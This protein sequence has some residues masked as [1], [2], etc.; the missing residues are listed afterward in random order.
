MSNYIPGTATTLAGM[1]AAAIRR[2][3]YSSKVKEEQVHPSVWTSIPTKFEVLGGNLVILDHGVCIDVSNEGKRAVGGGQSVVLT[4]S[5][6]LKKAP[7]EGTSEDMLGNGDEFTYSYLQCWYNEIK[8]A[9]KYNQWGF[10]FNDTEHL[11]HV[12]AYSKKLS[13]FWKELDALR[14]EQAFWLGFSSELTKAPTS[15]VQTLNPNWAIPALATSSY[16]TWDVD[17]VTVTDGSVNSYNWYPDRYYSGNGTFIENLAAAMLAG[18][19]VTAT[20]TAT[21]TVDNLLE[22]FNWMDENMVVESITLDGISTSRIFKATS[23]VYNWMMNPNNSG[24]IMDHWEAVASYVDK[25]PFQPGEMGRLFGNYIVVKDMRAPTLTVAGAVGSYTITFGWQFPGGNDGDS[26]NRSA[27]NATSGSENYVF[28]GCAVIGAEALARYTRDGYMDD[29]YE[30]TEFG[31]RQE[32]G[33]Y[34]GEGITL[35][36]FDKGTPTATTKKYCGGC[37]IPFAIKSVR[38]S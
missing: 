37:C 28:H 15:K 17:T 36:K 11:G 32:R 21:P 2:I 13:L 20:P 12:K 38:S 30:K 9:V 16:P 29:M 25:R 33:S 4:F 27:W 3:S 26:R 5:D 35:A 23:S 1:D 8:K 31:K 14:Y 18:S 10:D 34:K 19:G 22:M 24:A 6:N 7:Q